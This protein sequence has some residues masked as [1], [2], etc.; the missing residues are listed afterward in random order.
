MVKN[1]NDNNKILI[2]IGMLIFFFLCLIYGEQNNPY[3]DSNMC[4]IVKEQKCIQQNMTYDSFQGCYDPLEYRRIYLDI[5]CAL[6]DLE[7]KKLIERD[8]IK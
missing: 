3:S 5:N 1:M 2:L 7:Y 8:D 6:V 4:D